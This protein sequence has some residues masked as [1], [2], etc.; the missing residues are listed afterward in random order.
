MNDS[1]DGNIVYKKWT[2]WRVV[3]LLLFLSIIAFWIWALSPLAPQGHPDK[4]DDPAF[5]NAAKPLCADAKNSV[6]E[7]PLALTSKTP[8]ERADLIDEGTTIYRELLEALRLLAPAPNTNDGKNV[9]LWIDDYEIYLND[10]DQYA[11]K[12]RIGKDE[13]FVV[14]PSIKGDKWVTRPIDEF[15][16]ANDLKEC[17]VPLDV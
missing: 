2:V 9:N 17:M 12:F 6:E 13:A 10:R 15:A 8:D 1:S 7:L 5:A 4:L 3:S 14:S 16:K 11:E